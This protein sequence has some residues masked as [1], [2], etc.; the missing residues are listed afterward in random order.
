MIP[1]MISSA[2]RLKTNTIE[3]AAEST[4]VSGV[5]T[6]PVATADTEATA[7]LRGPR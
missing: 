2:T 5:A 3:P 1:A 4:D 6:S 7:V